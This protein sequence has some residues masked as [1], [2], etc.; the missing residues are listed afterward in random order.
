MR[1]QVPFST[2][3]LLIVAIN[4]L[5]YP[6]I[7]LFQESPLFAKW[8]TLQDPA[9]SWVTFVPGVSVLRHELFAHATV[10]WSSLRNMGAPILSNEI[11]AAP[12][13]PLTFVLVWVPDPYYWNVFVVLRIVLMWVGS[14]L[15]GSALKM[16]RTES[17][18]FAACFA[19][20]V[21]VARFV[22]HP[23]QNG[24]AAGVWFL[25]FV[26]RAVELASVPWGAARLLNTLGVTIATYATITCG[27]PEA[28][29]LT[30]ILAVLVVTPLF[31]AFLAG[32]PTATAI[33]RPVADLA[34]GT[35]TGAMLASPQILSLVENMAQTAPN[36]RK[37]VGLNQFSSLD[38]LATM[39]ARFHEAPPS[40]EMIQIF[41]LTTLTL[42]AAG[43][44]RPLLRRRVDLLD[45]IAVVSIVFYLLKAF[46][47]WP[48]FN[49]LIASLPLLRQ[50]W[51][52][53]YF[54]PILI[55]GVAIFAARGMRLLFL[56]SEQGIASRMLVATVSVALVGLAAWFYA[57]TAP[58]EPFYLFRTLFV[59]AVF[60]ATLALALLGR[61]N[62]A[63]T[64]VCVSA[65][66]SAVLQETYLSRPALFY[67]YK[68]ADYAVYGDGYAI[69]SAVRALLEERGIAIADVRESS[70][71]GRYVGAG[72]A[73]LD[74]G[75][76]AIL[77]ARAQ[78]FRTELFVVP[79]EGYLPIV[80]E[81]RK[82]AYRF[83]GRNLV[84]TATKPEDGLVT[85]GQVGSRLVQF[86]A[87]SPGRAFTA[88]RCRSASDITGAAAVMQEPSFEV[89]DV[90]VE[91]L[92]ETESPQCA[93]LDG[94]WK[95]VGVAEERGASVR[96]RR[97]NGPA[98]LT[99]NDSLYPGWRAFDRISGS[100]LAIKP[101]NINF[102]S[103]LLPEAMEYEVEFVYRPSWLA[104]ALA[105]I[106]AALVCWAVAAFVTFVRPG[107][108]RLR[109]A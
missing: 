67:P 88:A 27:F 35:L 21:V 47:V 81:K 90:V 48:A 19:G 10:L 98:I 49:E 14:M 95:T 62:A 34:F 60:L 40:R 18:C 38:V 55:L 2:F 91:G 23:W 15:L 17:L 24:L 106:A 13:F 78:R 51:F 9:V 92:T 66:L 107:K 102:R 6:G 58:A 26:V 8:W 77:T 36:F 84:I 82:D 59:F 11:Q 12:L 72:I 5:F 54:A 42:A 53:V 33:I 101:G 83:A 37:A 44:L 52:T 109:A 7:F 25:F 105:L 87:R 85:L 22:N 32:R 93:R 73:T 76:T 86:D 74:D 69:T 103:V 56:E 46:P 41:G 68:G 45:A 30:A 61:R 3:V 43:A 71:E 4:F 89:G 57:T 28:S 50:S 99:L 65:A 1:R 63:V 31:V 94:A 70:D 104:L 75:A 96:L 39:V 108:R 20:A 100:E 80:V 29:A 97:V 79:W 64:L 16:G